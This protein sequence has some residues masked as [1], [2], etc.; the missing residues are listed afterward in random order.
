MITF[1]RIVNRQDPFRTVNVSLVSTFYAHQAL[2]YG[3]LAFK[4]GFDAARCRKAVIA[5]G[6]EAPGKAFRCPRNFPSSDGAIFLP[7]DK[8]YP[9]LLQSREVHCSIDEGLFR[10]G[11]STV[12]HHQKHLDISVYDARRQKSGRKAQQEIQAQS[13]IIR[14]NRKVT[15]ITHTH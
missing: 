3:T 5:P 8:D 11:S 2:L 10:G 6:S 1:I 12:D 4:V 9:C 14:N 13:V 15:Y 7:L